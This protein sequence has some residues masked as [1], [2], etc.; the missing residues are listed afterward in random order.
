MSTE[1]ASKTVLRTLGR[2]LLGF[3]EPLLGLLFVAAIV[4]LPFIVLILLLFPILWLFMV[5]PLSGI[6]GAIA[7]IALTR[8]LIGGGAASLFD[9]ALQVRTPICLVCGAK[10]RERHGC[11]IWAVARRGRSLGRKAFLTRRG[12]YKAWKWNGYVLDRWG[13]VHH[14]RHNHWTKNEARGCA[15]HTV[16]GMQFGRLVFKGSI[17]TSKPVTVRIV[18]RPPI[19]DLPPATWEHMKKQAENKCY[20]CGV[21]PVRLHREHKIPLARGGPNSITNIVPACASCNQQK[22]ILTDE[23]FHQKLSEIARRGSRTV[24]TR[25]SAKKQTR[26]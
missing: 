22:G 21:V 16:R 2:G 1:P 6:G 9:R 11:F 20:Y 12:F 24:P 25:I 3:L 18:R 19:L 26:T 17:A 10:N 15:A 8:W 4:Y 23:E 7:A 5:H 14:C 13:D